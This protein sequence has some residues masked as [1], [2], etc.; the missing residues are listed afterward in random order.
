MPFMGRSA[1]FDVSLMH[2]D[3]TMA[4]DTVRIEGVWR[5]LRIAGWAFAALLLMLPAIAMQ[6]TSEV[7]WT[8]SDFIVMGALLG[9]IGLTTEYLVRRSGSTA[10]RIG[11]VIAMAT[12]F[13]TIWVNLAV[14]MIGDDNPYNLLFGGVLTVALAGSIMANF[15]PSGMARTMFTAA[16]A[17]ALAGGF[18]FAM[19]PRGAVLSM[20]FAFPW[21]LAG[22]LFRRAASDQGTSTVSTAS[23]SVSG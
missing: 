11:A 16:A 22:A 13:L 1:M 18:G 9:T 20:T 8:A 10:Y 6:F 21:I 14:G 19:D 17:Q 3:G 4:N 12:A 15:K 23:G 5:T 7:N 2:G